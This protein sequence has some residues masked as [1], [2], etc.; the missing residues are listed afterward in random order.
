MKN[1]S[2]EN[3]LKTITQGFEVGVDQHQ[4]NRVMELRA[5]QNKRK[6]MMWWFG[7]VSAVVIGVLFFVSTTQYVSTNS[8]NLDVNQ[9]VKTHIES[10]VTI[11][12]NKEK[13]TTPYLYKKQHE[14]KKSNQSKSEL[15]DNKRI[16]TRLTT[17]IK[18][19]KQT[20]LKASY[21]ASPKQLNSTSSTEMFLNDTANNPLK[22][23]TISKPVLIDGH[24]FNQTLLA[25][26]NLVLPKENKTYEKGKTA[27]KTKLFN[28]IYLESTY[29]PFTSAK[30]ASSLM[31]EEKASMV[32]LTEDANFAHA[33]NV[34]AVFNLSKS[35]Q[36]LA[37]VGIHT[38]RFDKIRAVTITVD[39]MFE[40]LTNNAKK[41]NFEHVAD[42]SFTWLDLPI[43]LR[44][45][46]P[47]N[48]KFNWYVQ[49]G[50]N[51]RYLVQNKAY[52]FQVD[53]NRLESYELRTNHANNRINKHQLAIVLDPGITYNL[54]RN[55]AVN[56]GVPF[57]YNL[58]AVYNKAY[59]DRDKYKL[60]GVKAGIQF[61][62]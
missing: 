4:F 46:K 34:G 21:S 58:L 31:P 38:I 1:S 55:I 8:E 2:F 52:V 39:T 54:T 45:N 29:F 41:I 23:T 51:Y 22:L 37:G 32:G 18:T 14:D 16:R 49:A 36:L 6:K 43:A 20:K 28:G 60:L 25:K 48:N 56:L 24:L 7:S 35:L 40:S 26:Q 12:T 59:A 53:S 62:F 42:F 27:P 57:Q 19:T 50:L 47:I 9:H 17:P 44:Y 13:L 11:Q 15:T 33:V 30:N 3:N 61:N 5:Q 10:S